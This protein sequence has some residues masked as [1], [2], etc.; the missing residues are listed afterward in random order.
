MVFELEM[1]VARLEEESGW[2]ATCLE[3]WGTIISPSSHQAATCHFGARFM[4]LVNN[5]ISVD[6]VVECSLHQCLG[7]PKPLVLHVFFPWLLPL[8][9]FKSN[10]CWM[11]LMAQDCAGGWL[12]SYPKGAAVD[13][14]HDGIIS[15]LQIYYLMIFTYIY[16]LD[17]TWCWLIL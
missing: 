3:Q 1:P 15:Y 16:I 8:F 9:P 12:H 7:Y 4:A 17:V 11:I 10:Q 6:Q 13:Q 14:G 5:H 2:W